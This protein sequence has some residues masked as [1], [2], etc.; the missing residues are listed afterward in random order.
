[1]KCG[2]GIGRTWRC[3]ASRRNFF[4]LMLLIPCF[5]SRNA[6]SNSSTSKYGVYGFRQLGRL[7]P[8]SISTLL[9]MGCGPSS[10]DS[11]LS[12]RI[13]V[14]TGGPLSIS[15]SPSS[16]LLFSPSSAF[17]SSASINLTW[18]NSYSAPL[19][20]SI[21]VASCGCLVLTCRT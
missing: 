9:W 18:L 14:P 11:I 1:M 15:V 19:L 3:S 16:P 20:P 6:N 7:G 8:T 10:W 21:S 4:L 13:G 12:T 2:A 17:S 5:I